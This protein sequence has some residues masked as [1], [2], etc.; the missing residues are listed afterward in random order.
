MTDG[1]PRC[2]APSVPHQTRHVAV[3]RSLQ[4]GCWRC[5]CDDMECGERTQRSPGGNAA[6]NG[7]Q[8]L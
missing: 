3:A 6:E 2:V 8:F 4:V 7:S 1:S 5:C